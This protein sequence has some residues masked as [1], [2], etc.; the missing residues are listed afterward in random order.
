MAKKKEKS[1]PHEELNKELDTKVESGMRKTNAWAEIWQSSLRY[2][3]SE[4]L[5]GKKRH[6]NWDWVI[7]NYI[8]PSAIQEISKLSKNHPKII[9]HPWEDSDTDTA[10]AW[11]SKLQWDW[12]K[13]LNKHGMRLEQ[14]TAILD[15]KI[16][17]YR[18]SKIYWEGQ[19]EWDDD[20]KE[21]VGEVRHRLWHPGQFW[22]SDDEKIEDGD[23]GTL[24]YVTLGWAKRRWPEFADQLEKESEEFAEGISG[25]QG[26]RGSYSA[27]GT[28]EAVS[29][30]RFGGGTEKEQAIKS[31][32]VSLVVGADKTS[33]QSVPKDTKIVKIEEIYFKD[34]ST[35]DEKLEEDIPKEELLVNKQVYLQDGVYYDAATQ[36]PIKIESWPKRLVKEWKQPKFPRGRYVI[37]CGHTILN[38]EEKDQVWKYSRWPFIVVPHYLLPH[39]WQGS[40]AVEMYKSVQDMLNISISHLFNNMKLFGDP[41]IAVEN[42]AIAINPKTGKHFRI[43][44]GA[45]AVI[46]LVRGG[47][48]RFNIFTPPAPAAGAT[49]LYQLFAQ[50]FKNLTGLQGVARGEQLKGRTTATEASHLAMS[51]YDRIAL[52]SVY[53][54]EWIRG[55]MLLD[56]EISQVNYSTDRFIRIV[57]EDKIVGVAQI[58]RRM[59]LVKFDVDVEPGSSLP[60]DPEKRQAK[61]LQIYTLLRDPTPHPM[62][63]EV[64]RE[65]EI[66]NWRKILNRHQIWLKWMQFLAL[67][68][69]VTAGEIAPQEAVKLLVRKTM[70]F[71]AEEQQNQIP[72]GEQKKENRKAK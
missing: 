3:F 2:F 35:T 10:E 58:T 20:K 55:I 21:W 27:S 42:D 41:K 29:S 67:Y 8:W 15:G 17:G 4:Q 30:G 37:R 7:I 65:F 38:P 34:Y 70:Q 26:I 13:G 6:K 46:R 48:K 64:M 57:G 40:N 44:A 50:E 32:L 60:Y 71:Y 36:E 54:D 45:G 62:I 52:Q 59:K 49:M 12:Q 51:S 39:M 5:E 61:Y 56:A 18:V 68:E 14:I 72:T 66:P 53:E 23:C 63:E 28:T 25:K 24:R 16:F 22:A 69:A 19:E 43:G 33:S 1:D 11:Q 9:V 47:L 31:P